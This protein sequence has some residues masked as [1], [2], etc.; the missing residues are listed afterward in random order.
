MLPLGGIGIN[1]GLLRQKPRIRERQISERGCELW[2][3]LWGTGVPWLQCCPI[4]EQM[5][6]MREQAPHESCV[7][8]TIGVGVG[9]C[10]LV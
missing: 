2:A 3:R 1:L 5:A 6:R 4:L 10:G 7:A 8:W 9:W